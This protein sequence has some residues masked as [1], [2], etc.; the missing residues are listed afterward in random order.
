MESSIIASGRVNMVFGRM[1]PSNFF[2][3]IC[4]SFLL[5]VAFATYYGYVER[6]FGLTP[7]VAVIAAHASLVVLLLM[8]RKPVRNAL[9]LRGCPRVAW[10]PGFAV[11]AG[12]CLLA[13]FSDHSVRARPI[14]VGLDLIYIVSTLSVVPLLEEIVFRCGVSPMISRVAGSFWGV[15]FA[16]V[17]FSLVHTNP[18]WG[19]VLALKVGLPLG[20]FLLAICS[21][22]IIRRWGRVMPGVF[23]H[24]C[25][26]GTVYIFSSLNPSWLG[27]LGGLYV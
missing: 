18:T 20:P 27:K 4:S 14:V 2:L 3:I 1:S 6:E 25:C 15:W 24:A 26:N 16:A 21:D 12:A 17:I 11:L 13:G 5:A 9:R 10:L 19:R 23:F 22:M 7:W 8:L